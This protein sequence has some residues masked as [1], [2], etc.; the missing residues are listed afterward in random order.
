MNSQPSDYIPYALDLEAT[1]LDDVQIVLKTIYCLPVT[2]SHSLNFFI[3]KHKNHT[4]MPGTIC[5]KLIFWTDNILK[6]IV[7]KFE[8][9]VVT[10]E[11]YFTHICKSALYNPTT[12]HS[13]FVV[14]Y[15]RNKHGTPLFFSYFL[16]VYILWNI[17]YKYGE[18]VV[19]S[20][21]YPP[22]TLKGS[23]ETSGG[24]V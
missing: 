21:L 9:P 20:T 12:G 10:F 16:R 6:N 4:N 8:E 14:K 5:S 18:I 1:E 11:C 17:W 23:K 24:S 22:A 2:R 3:S 15:L 7:L 19:T 13:N